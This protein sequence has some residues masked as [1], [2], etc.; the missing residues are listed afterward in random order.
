MPGFR[1]LSGTRNG[2]RW[3]YANQQGKATPDGF[4]QEDTIRAIWA[5]DNK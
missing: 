4:G 5:A 3:Y 1:C 2:K